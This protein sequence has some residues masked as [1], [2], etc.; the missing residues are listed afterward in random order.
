MT[1]QRAHTNASTATARSLDRLLPR[2]LGAKINAILI[3]YF[4]FALAVILLTLYAAR[5][6]EGEGAAI[7]DAGSERMHIYDL[8][9]Q[10]H[11]MRDSTLTLYRLEIGDPARPLFL[12]NEPRIKE[13]MAILK[14]EWRTNLKPRIEILLTDLDDTERRGL[15][16]NFDSKVRLYVTKLNELVSMVEHSNA[17]NT[18]LMFVFQNILVA[19]A[20]LGT[21]LLI[22]LF[23]KLVIEP[24]EMLRAGIE[25]M[26]VSDFDVRLPVLSKDE[27]GELAVGFNHMAD[28]LKELYATLE[29]RV[30]EKTRSVEERNRELALLYEITAYLGE[31]T[32]V[33]AVC[34]GVLVKLRHQL[35]A[36]AGVVRLFEAA[37]STLDIAVN[38]NMPD[39]FITAEARLPVG[40]CLCSEVAR[41]GSSIAQD[42]I[43]SAPVMM[44][45]QCC[46][47][48]GY[49]AMTAIPIRSKKHAIGVLNLFFRDQRIIS[50]HEIRLLE[51]IG[52][53]L[54]VTI[55]NLRLV[56][57]EKE[58]AVSEER[59]LLAQE[60]HDSI[61]QSLAFLNIQAQM[62]QES[63]RNG[64]ANEADEELA[65][66]REG[67]QE[68]YDDVRELLVH[69]RIKVDHAKLDDA[70]RNTLEKFEGQTGIRTVL[71]VQS[72]LQTPPATSL[73]QML[74][75][76]QEALS[77]VR[78]HAKASSVTVDLR[79]GTDLMISVRDDGR[80]FEPEKVI[81]QSGSCVG[82]G[83]M[84][85]RAHR[86]GARLEV[87]SAP[88]FGACVTLTLPR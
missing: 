32:T 58:M 76:L 72:D 71:N 10:L 61:A 70:I 43:Q 9:L 35:G 74:H 81:E 29:Q 31:H 78:K 83:I 55:D 6:L 33:E 84:R 5:Q 34:N 12:P 3:L 56:V 39:Q 75:I 64:H 57:R 52:Q 16:V 67:I 66:I 80:G 30:A 26:A 38:H 87:A 11:Q 23:R 36:P 2:K 82:I 40:A 44:S 37:T 62:L 42:L 27:F 68:S 54:G 24:V 77:N 59:N 69:F 18:F 20:L 65:R 4:V 15:L 47:Q 53:H 25:R 46:K 85:E 17:R 28:H 1:D 50:P 41:H 21:I 48:A 14:R 51:A 13:Q 73:I 88:G 7:N 45:M 79:G 8:T 19:F 22:Y 60:L 49:A 63:L 86:I